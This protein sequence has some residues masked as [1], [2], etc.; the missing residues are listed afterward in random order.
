VLLSQ[1]RLSHLGGFDDVTVPLTSG[2]SDPQRFLVMFGGE[3]TGKTALLAAVASTRPGHAI[4]HAPVTDPADSPPFSVADWWLGDDDPGRPHLLRVASPNARLEGEREDA[5]VARRREQALFDRRATQ[6]GFVLA[7]FS[8]ARWFSRTAVLLTTPER[9]ILRYDPRL[10][11]VFDDPT[12]ADLARETKQV[13]S[14]SAVAAALEA[15]G[16]HFHAFD[17]AL[18]GALGVVLE[19]S[20]AEYVG[21]DP[22]TLEPVFLRDGREVSFDD[23]PRSARHRVAFV[24]LTVRVL[25]AAYPLRDPREA[26]G[27]VLIDDVELEQDPRAQEALPG[28]LRRSLPRV[29]WIV[30][31]ASPHIAMAVEAGEVLALRK[32]PGADGVEVYGGL[33]AIMH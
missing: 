3:G 22:L 5:V 7:A 21:T 16:A 20:G 31:T 11:P 14:F 1:I 28:L 10:A 6:G 9:T 33:S 30:T 8:G 12:R 26:E 2:G 24:A 25:Y 32:M 13:L 29:Q 19:D 23:L 18:R 17:A 27:V 4:A 15:K